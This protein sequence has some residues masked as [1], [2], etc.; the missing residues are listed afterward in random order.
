M[1]VPEFFALLAGVCIVG[2]VAVIGGAVSL[3]VLALLFGVLA[4][5]AAWRGVS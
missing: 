5:L 1:A 3:V 4:V 2:A